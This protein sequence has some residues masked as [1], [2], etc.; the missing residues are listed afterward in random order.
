[1]VGFDQFGGQGVVAVF[2]VGERIRGGVGF[3]GGGFGEFR[4]VQPE[5]KMALLWQGEVRG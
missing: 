5:M 2:E 3:D 4:L 1:M